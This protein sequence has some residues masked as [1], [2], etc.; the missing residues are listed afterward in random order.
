MFFRLFISLNIY[1]FLIPHAYSQTI[2][3]WSKTDDAVILIEAEGFDGTSWHGSGF[4]I[5]ESGI[6]VTNYH[7]VDNAR[8]LKV[9][10]ESSNVTGEKYDVEVILK[11]DKQKDLAVIQI[12][13]RNKVVFPFL[14]LEDSLPIKGSEC[15]AIGTPAGKEY[16]NSISKGLIANIFF[17]EKE[18][19]RLLQ[20]NAPFTHGSS[21]GALLNNEGRVIGVTSGG[22]DDV[23]GARAMINFAVWAGEII[24]LP[25]INQSRIKS[26]HPSTYASLGFVLSDYSQKEVFIFIDGVFMGKVYCKNIPENIDCDDDRILRLR[27]L[28]GEHIVG[29]ALSGSS[30][31]TQRRIQVEEGQCP[32]YYISP[33]TISNQW[34]ILSSN[35]TK[36]TQREI[37]D[38]NIKKLKNTAL[39][40]RLRTQENLINTLIER[41]D[42]ARV[43]LIQNQ[44]KAKNVDVIRGFKSHF[45]FCPTYFVMSN[46]TDAITRGKWGEVVFR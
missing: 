10:T 18:N 44:Q 3:D 2:V 38:Y 31:I 42:T 41:G 20:I 8:N 43:R 27:V 33:N 28:S 32:V 45:N 7:V 11:G 46:Q 5:S 23:N 12:V 6:I 1:F 4:F 9:T 36:K 34:G 26:S 13:N 15:W 30:N 29:I 24:S 21:G 14:L 17:E 37:A 22:R 16:M 39:I 35:T 40:V 25:D 19:R